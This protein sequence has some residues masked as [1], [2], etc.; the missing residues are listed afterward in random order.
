MAASGALRGRKPESVHFWL[1][2]AAVSLLFHA[3]LI[4]GIKRW[5]TIAVVEPDAGPIAIELVD[6]SGDA[7]P[8]GEPIVQA[9]A[10]KPEAKPEA[11]SE[12]QPEFEIKLEPEI[13]SEP[14]VQPEVKAEKRAIAPKENRKP[15]VK[16]IVQEPNNAPK[17]SVKPSSKPQQS[18]N[19]NPSISPNPLPTIIVPITIDNPDDRPSVYVSPNPNVTLTERSKIYLGV[20]GGTLAIVHPSTLDVPSEL[21]SQ[22]SPLQILIEFNIDTEANNCTCYVSIDSPPITAD[23]R[24]VK[25]MID[26]LC[27]NVKFENPTFQGQT[28]VKLAPVSSWKQ[29]IEFQ[30]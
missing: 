23:I 13:K 24:G 29:M 6:P 27:E 4:V 26:Q 28:A 10:M 17:P 3:L 5:A 7:A 20:T 30:F 25:K 15:E 9:A 2:I 1:A 16:P 8:E 12:V 19:P 18:S 11:K 21:K 22:Q 14:I